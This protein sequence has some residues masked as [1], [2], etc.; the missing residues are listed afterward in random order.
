MYAAVSVR[1]AG[2]VFVPSYVIFDESG[3][4]TELGKA[5][6][7]IAK[8]RGLNIE[9]MTELEAIEL[10]AGPSPKA[11]V[12]VR[13]HELPSSALIAAVQAAV[14]APVVVAE[15]EPVAEAVVE[16]EAA[17]VVAEIPTVVEPEPV[18]AAPVVVDTAKCPPPA[19]GKYANATVTPRKQVAGPA[20]KVTGF[21]PPTPRPEPKPQ[22]KLTTDELREQLGLRRR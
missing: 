14:A 22:R 7:V 5:A 13:Q 20:A 19:H 16:V 17:P 10:V 12:R 21:I 2:P 18:V 4:L 8:A 9:T 11:K 6:I 3:A 15:P 1:P